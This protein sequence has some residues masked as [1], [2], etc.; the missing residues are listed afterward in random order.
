MP[1]SVSRWR[2]EAA[3]TAYSPIAD[4][5]PASPLPCARGRAAPAAAQVGGRV[6]GRPRKCGRDRG[7]GGGEKRHR[8]GEHEDAGVDADRVDTRQPFGHERHECAQRPPRDRQADGSRG[9]GQQQAL[10]EQLARQPARTGAERGAHRELRPPN[11]SSQG[12]QI[13]RVRARD[14]EY[15]PDGAGQ[16]EQARAHVTHYHVQVGAKDRLQ[17][18]GASAGVSISSREISAESSLLALLY[19]RG[20]PQP[21]DQSDVT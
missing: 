5:P 7:C 18:C 20:R 12:Q 9:E 15:E 1:I 14:E 8:E 3:I 2:T 21:G 6:V 17:A 10:G 16:Q 4:E 19:R 11:L 13:R